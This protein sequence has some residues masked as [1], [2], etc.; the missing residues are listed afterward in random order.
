MS[1]I[2]EREKNDETEFGVMV[3]TEGSNWAGGTEDIGR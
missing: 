1:L 3:E 2:G